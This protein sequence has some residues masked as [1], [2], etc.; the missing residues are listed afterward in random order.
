MRSDQTAAVCGETR[1]TYAELN[2]RVDRLASGLEAAASSRTR[3]CC[4]LTRTASAAV[5][6]LGG[7]AARGGLLPAQLALERRGVEF[8]ISDT[9]PAIVI[10]QPEEVDRRAG[11]A[12]LETAPSSDRPMTMLYT[13][14]FEGRS[15]GA[16][17]SHANHLLHSRAMAP[18][19]EMGP[20]T[21]VLA[22][23]PLFHMATL[24]RTL[25]TFVAGG[26]NVFPRAEPE[27]ICAVWNGSVSCTPSW[28]SRPSAVWPS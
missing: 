28:S 12:G 2:G 25:A 20:D 16:L 23:G 14:A 15:K 26:T 8:A 22:S 4:G 1:L 18:L 27:E 7:G 21:V 13:A 24:W 5:D 9:R 17:F 3:S 6:A 10:R 19:E 11:E